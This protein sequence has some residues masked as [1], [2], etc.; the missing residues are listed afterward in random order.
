MSHDGISILV[1]ERPDQYEIIDANSTVHSKASG[2][3]GFLW[4]LQVSISRLVPPPAGRMLQSSQS[5]RLSNCVIRFLK[6]FE[7]RK[8]EA[9][10]I[11]NLLTKIKEGSSSVIAVLATIRNSV[12]KICMFS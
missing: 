12:S 1:W 10:A 4:L 7:A 5:S 9:M 6:Q 2:H 8:I 11:G 3:S